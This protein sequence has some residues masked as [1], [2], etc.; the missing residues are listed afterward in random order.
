MEEASCDYGNTEKRETR[1]AHEYDAIPDH[2]V[3]LRTPYVLHPS[4]QTERRTFFILSTWCSLISC[5]TQFLTMT[6]LCGHPFFCI[7]AG[8]QRDG[9]FS[10]WRRD[11]IRGK[12]SFA[13]GLIFICIQKALLR[14]IKEPKKREM[15]QILLTKFPFPCA[16]KTES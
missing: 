15:M 1:L 6:S 11:N 3:T 8:R 5:M 13:C 2:D 4:W 16:K 9:Q 7:P 12:R 10:S 14:E